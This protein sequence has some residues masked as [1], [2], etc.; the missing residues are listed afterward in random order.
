MSNT[1]RTIILSILFFPISLPYWFA[2]LL[3]EII[4]E[5]DGTIWTRNPL[6]IDTKN[7]D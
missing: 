2:W 5:D 4:R 6:T 1:L 3:I 7:Y